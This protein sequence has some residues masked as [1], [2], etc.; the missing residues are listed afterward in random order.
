MTT[1][2][3]N[4]GNPLE[5]TKCPATPDRL[6][7]MYWKEG[8]SMGE[9]AGILSKTAEVQREFSAVIVMH[10]MK[11]VGITPRSKSE[12]YKLRLKK[13]PSAYT[14]E[15]K[16]EN[17]KKARN[18]YQTHE[19]QPEIKA[20]ILQGL[21]KARRVSAKNRRGR[22]SDD[23]VLMCDFWCCRKEFQRERS[24]AVRYI[25]HFCSK[26][27][28]VKFRHR[29]SSLEKIRTVHPVPEVDEQTKEWAERILG[30][31]VEAG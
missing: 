12:A 10:W 18:I 16:R 30:R 28:A 1:E 9:M 5:R 20:K 11:K 15:Q 27:C 24:Q 26:S 17:L 2:S 21:K 6:W 7:E 19:R 23:V 31:K 3:I 25:N 14:I 29:E 8:K 4:K 13:Y 22:S